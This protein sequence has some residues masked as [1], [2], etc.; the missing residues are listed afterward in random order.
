MPRVVSTG[1]YLAVDTLQRAD[2]V[3]VDFGP[4]AHDDGRLQRTDR[5]IQVVGV[6]KGQGLDV[7]SALRKNLHEPLG[8]EVN[9]RFA[10]RRPADAELLRDQVEIDEFAGFE[11][12]FPDLRPQIVVYYIA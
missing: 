11:L 8:F 3:L 2:E 1:G 7:D 5:L 9:K 6:L 4:H 10:K 12:L